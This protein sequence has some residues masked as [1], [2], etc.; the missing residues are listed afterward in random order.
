LGNRLGK[1]IGSM[2]NEMKDALGAST[3]QLTSRKLTAA[4]SGTTVM[5]WT[6]SGIALAA[7]GSHGSQ[8]VHGLIEPVPGTGG[9]VFARK[10]PVKLADFY[11]DVTGV[12]GS[13]TPDGLIT[14]ED[15][16]HSE[17]VDANGEALY[18]SDANG[19]VAIPDHFVGR[20][21]VADFEGATDTGT[22]R[23]F[24]ARMMRSLPEGGIASPLTELIVSE[25]AAGTYPDVEAVLAALFPAAAGIT[26]EDILD[27]ENYRIQDPA[28]S[29][30]TTILPTTPTPEQMASYKAY[31][32]ERAAL[33]VAESP[34]D[35]AG[36]TMA[37]VAGTNP[38]NVLVDTDQTNDG[39]LGD[40]V[41]DLE[42]AGAA[43]LGGKPVAAPDRVSINE[44]GSYTFNTAV[45]GFIDPG[46]NTTAP[47]G[48]A[49]ILIKAEAVF[50]GS[51]LTIRYE[52][53]PGTIGN[54]AADVATRPT[55][56][57]TP[58]DAGFWY[59]P[60]ADIPNLSIAPG[61][62]QFGTIEIQY[63]V[64]D[65]EEWSDSDPM[66]NDPT[67]TP[68]PATLKITVN[69]V[70]DAPTV[71]VT[72]TRLSAARE[73][74]GEDDITTTAPVAFAIADADTTDPV[75][76]LTVRAVASESSV[77]AHPAPGAT[78][79]ETVDGAYG[80][81]TVTREVSGAMTATYRLFTQAE[82]ADAYNAVQALND[83][84][85]LTDTLRV[86]ARDD[87]AAESRAL[88]Y[89]VTIDGA[90]DAAPPVAGNTAPTI[91][92]TGSSAA[93]ATI[94]EDAVDDTN[95]S[96]VDE[97]STTAVTFSIA[98]ADATDPVD[99]LTVRALASGGATAPATPGY[100]ATGF[101]A[102]AHPAS[103]MTTQTV[104]G[105]Y[106]VFT[107]TRDTSGAMTASYDVDETDTTV[108]ALNTGDSLF[109]KLVVF[110]HDGD[111]PST[112]LTYTVEIE[113]ADEPNRAPTT[114]YAV[115]SDGTETI[116]EDETGSTTA[117]TFTIADA[118]TAADPVDGLTVRAMATNA[119]GAADPAVPA[120]TDI[121]VS[122]G[123]GTDGDADITTAGSPVTVTGMY[124][125][126]TVTRTA[127][128]NGEM[129]VTYNVDETNTAVQALGSSTDLLKE[130]LTLYAHDGDA[131]SG[132]GTAGLTYTVTI[133]GANDAPREGVWSAAADAT[134]ALSDSDGNSTND[135][136]TVT[137]SAPASGV[138]DTAD[139]TFTVSDPDT[140]D[141][142]ANLVIRTAVADGTS[143]PADP[144]PSGADP[145]IDAGDTG[146]VAGVYGVFTITRHA[147]DGT[148][149]VSYNLTDDFG[150]GGAMALTSD[151]FDELAI[152]T[153][154]DE[155][156]AAGDPL[157][158]TVHIDV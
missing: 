33:G 17:N 73:N 103:G 20:A 41:D 28:A 148:A 1:G 3:N 56:T 104:M 152:M 40:T 72:A 58:T 89:T 51:T 147:T 18:S 150:S 22:G 53:Q 108:Q 92:Y 62:D 144:M 34:V 107:V 76:G 67:A 83:N 131:A 109:D 59:V 115:G 156:T 126:F 42:T 55:V 154:D 141:T 14:A 132:G 139:Q 11:F 45:F 90:N 19:E 75:S 87:D 82:N 44:D 2:P 91:T 68:D 86:F 117:H 110:A 151:V 158:Y 134:H 120:Y 149:T 143:N 13:T 15:L 142:G 27:P 127:N 157:I 70:N 64:F 69:S 26:I 77:L 46:G 24:G 96:S 65:G 80:I 125:V 32:I 50:D 81:F 133:T 12:G 97:G 74:I 99:G 37:T 113:G 43:N 25:L 49:G 71:L 61:A 16:A 129:T 36:A 21:F 102:V 140:A 30:T 121:D 84:F 138:A 85:T 155:G 8:I 66:N 23:V 48:L 124:G 78:T 7:C 93:T 123:D 130:Q 35:A 39:A 79:T 98:D 137:L 153:F 119:A 100:P 60:A 57:G 114:T 54:L 5:V 88:T 52:S 135:T 9:S 38:I 6:I 94:G 116:T 47:T 145:S 111:D 146:T 112:A 29:T 105:M 10:G 128:N 95:T 31:I 106:G 4:S 63:Y 101:T 118:D 136:V 122:D